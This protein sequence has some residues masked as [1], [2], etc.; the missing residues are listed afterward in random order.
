VYGWFLVSMWI[1][2]L[3]A[4]TWIGGLAFIAMVLVPTLRRPELRP[5][6]LTLL[7][8]SGTKFMRIAYASLVT[9]VVTGGTNLWLK[10]GGS[11]A[12]VHALMAGTYGRLLET[13]VTLVVIVIAV[14]L[15]HDFVVGPAATRA[16]EADPQGAAALALRR[17]ASWIGRINTLL[18]LVIMTLALLLVRGVPA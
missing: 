15:Y 12:G 9:L 1:H 16:L 17:R 7:R 13:K 6:A 8:V 3:A 18:S 11:L 5:Q 14:A 2:L 4:I 10:A